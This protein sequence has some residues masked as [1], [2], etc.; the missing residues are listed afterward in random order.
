MQMKWKSV[1]SQKIL[2]WLYSYIIPQNL[3]K[4][5]CTCNNYWTIYCFLCIFLKLKLEGIVYVKIYS[6]VSNGNEISPD[7]SLI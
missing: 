3:N 5:T 6:K 2:Y 4:Y 1:T 7:L